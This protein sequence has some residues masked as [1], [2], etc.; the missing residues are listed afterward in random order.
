MTGAT[1]GDLLRSASGHLDTAARFSDAGLLDG[2]VIAVTRQACRVVA[3]MSHY[4]DDIVPYSD[5]E[6][7]ARPRMEPWMR[8]AVDAREALTLVAA[9]LDPGASSPGSASG[10]GAAAA[11]PL[12]ASLARAS[13]SLIA[14]RDLLHTHFVT[15]DDGIRSGH[16]DWSAVVTSVPVTRAL[17]D[18]I[19]SWSRPLAILAGQLT[20]ASRSE[21]CRV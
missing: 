7:A 14:G 4:L 12:E 11:D 17:L 20:L 5:Y 10:H 8:A 9:N 2:S 15:G 16:S 1:C 6:K 19:A 13:T 18:E 21:E 3:A